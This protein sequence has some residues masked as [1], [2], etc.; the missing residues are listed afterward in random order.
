[1][2][3]KTNPLDK[4]SYFL[5]NKD[6]FFYRYCDTGFKDKW[7]GFWSAGTKFLEFFD[8][9]VNN[10]FLGEK[11]CISVYYDSLKAIHSHELSNGERVNKKI[12]MPREKPT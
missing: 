3:S 8:F 2:I 11:N 6:A 1:M 7:T 5:S 4:Y 12:W 9:Q 10:E